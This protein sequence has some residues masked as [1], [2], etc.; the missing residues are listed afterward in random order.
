L[1][2]KAVVNGERGIEEEG[3]H[4]GKEI[5]NRINKGGEEIS[6][7]GVFFHEVRKKSKERG[8]GYK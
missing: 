5:G 6:K 2:E 1:S 3:S 4:R 8:K 7:G